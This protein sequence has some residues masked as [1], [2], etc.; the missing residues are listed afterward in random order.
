MNERPPH[1][2]SPSIPDLPDGTLLR[3]APGEWSHCRTVPDGSP[4][5]V[6]VC[7]VHRNVTR[8]DGADLWVWIVG[9]EHPSCT[10]PHVESHPPCLQ[11]MVRV[12]VLARVVEP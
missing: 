12:D 6:T 4:L 3:L 1:L 10:W 2:V 7:R 9:H 8:Q 11:L 5:N